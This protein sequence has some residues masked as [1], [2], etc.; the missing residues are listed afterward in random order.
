MES[1]ECPACG[2]KAQKQ[3]WLPS[4]VDGSKVCGMSPAW[5]SWSVR[6][7]EKLGVLNSGIAW[8]DLGTCRAAPISSCM[9]L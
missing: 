7:I 6:R 5:T 2:T 1:I 3:K 4:V 9:D 8:G